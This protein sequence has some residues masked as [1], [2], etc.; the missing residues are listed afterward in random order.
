MDKV[1]FLLGLLIDDGLDVKLSMR[2]VH[3]Y[4]WRYDFALVIL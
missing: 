4:T 1:K 3:D 2:C